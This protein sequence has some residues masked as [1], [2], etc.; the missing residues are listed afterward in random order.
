M[1]ETRQTTIRFA[2]P[3]YWRLEA[4]SESTGLP[5]NSIVISACLAWLQ[6]YEPALANLTDFAPSKQLPLS[7]GGKSNPLNPTLKAS[8]NKR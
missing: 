5:I 8:K 2:E 4:A 6:G 3:L 1:S 7:E